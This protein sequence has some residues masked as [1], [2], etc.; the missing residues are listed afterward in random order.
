MAATVNSLPKT[1]EVKERAAEIGGQLNEK[2][3]ELGT[4]VS[5]RAEEV[6]SK[7]PELHRPEAWGVNV[8]PP[9]R[10][11][12]VVGGLALVGFGI[13]RRTPASAALG[14]VGGYL[15]VRGL[16]GHCVLYQGLG[17][18]RMNGADLLDG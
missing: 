17:I 10:M 3:H 11:L 16:S 4:Q 6:A 1:E 7:L 8:G 13:V 14:L 9:E 2:A 5:Q 15:L 18:D 12:S